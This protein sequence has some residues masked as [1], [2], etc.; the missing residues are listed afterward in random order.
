IGAAARLLE[1]LIVEVP[2]EHDVVVDFYTAHSAPLADPDVTEQDVRAVLN[3]AGFPRPIRRI[4]VVAAAAGDPQD[5]VQPG[6]RLNHFTYR[7]SGRAFEEDRFYRGVHPMMGKRLHLWR[8]ENFAIE[9]L[10][11]VEDIYL[12]HGVA[13]DNPKDERLFACAEVR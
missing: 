7:Q 4:V 5:P 11:S 9:R 1:P 13:R 10:P 6:G 2:P 8:L 12:I 3:Q